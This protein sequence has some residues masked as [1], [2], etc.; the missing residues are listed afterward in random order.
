MN[1]AQFWITSRGSIVAP[2]TRSLRVAALVIG[3]LLLSGVP[4]KAQDERPE[5][6]KAL[7]LENAGKY[8]DAAVILRT[9]VRTAP[10]PT[11]VLA[12]ERVYAELGQSDSLL[13][14]I[15]TLI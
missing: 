15:D 8:K 7:D 2:R 13:G 1:V 4:S 12:L 5:V 6:I 10:T 9:A 11:A 3:G 14:P